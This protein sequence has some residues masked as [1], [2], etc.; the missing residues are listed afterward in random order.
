[1]KKFIKIIILV[2][3]C[4]NAFSQSNS[5]YYWYNGEKYALQLNPQKEFLLFKDTVDKNVL[6]DSLKIEVDRV[7]E[8]RKID[9]GA[10]LKSYDMK[11]SEKENYYWTVCSVNNNQINH[12]SKILLYHSPYYFSS[13]GEELGLTHLFYVK[14]NKQEDV[15]FLED[16]AEKNKVKILGNNK[17]M[18]L[19]YTLSCDRFS[20]GNA[21]QMA[22]LF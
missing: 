21:L 18:P 5:D 2:L 16:L 3:L 20:E 8:I 1:M 22:N 12:S 4:S 11:G 6:L 10:S 14:L 7:S 17:F 15:V 9:L 13:S 19:W